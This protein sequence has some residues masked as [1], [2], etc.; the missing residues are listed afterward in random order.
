MWKHIYHNSQL[1]TMVFIEQLSD[2][3]C[4]RVEHTSKKKKKKKSICTN[5]RAYYE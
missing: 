1:T 4:L 2:K 3:S 5:Q